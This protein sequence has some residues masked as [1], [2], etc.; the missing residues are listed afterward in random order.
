[1][2]L[3]Q[4][5]TKHFDGNICLRTRE[6]RINAVSDGSANLDID[7]RD[8]CETV[9]DIVHYLLLTTLVQHEGCLYLRHVHPECML[10]QFGTSGLSSHRLNLRDAE[11]LLLHLATYLIRSL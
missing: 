6:H 8:G 11:E 2:H 1:M 3:F 10:V 9:T 4:V 5:V 7:T